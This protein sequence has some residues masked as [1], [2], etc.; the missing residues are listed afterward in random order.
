MFMKFCV[1]FS[2]GDVDYGRILIFHVAP[3]MLLEEICFLTTT[4]FLLFNYTMKLI[5]ACISVNNKSYH[6]FNNKNSN[7]HET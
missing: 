1:I 2:H 6:S 5:V 3:L 4:I 7:I